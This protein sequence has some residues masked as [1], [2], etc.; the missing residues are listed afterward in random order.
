MSNHKIEELKNVKVINKNQETI[1]VS[2]DETLSLQECVDKIQAYREAESKELGFITDSDLEACTIYKNPECPSKYILP[3]SSYFDIE[4]EKIDSAYKF[5][6]SYYEK[7][8]VDSEGRSYV[9]DATVILQMYSDIDEDVFFTTVSENEDT[10]VQ[11][12]REYE[13][14]LI[15]N[16][17]DSA[18]DNTKN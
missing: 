7:L 13:S 5:S 11:Q 6:A 15:R 17:E 9:A 10:T 3:I 14:E 8:G 2:F 16:I 4:A 18:Q 12:L 1:R